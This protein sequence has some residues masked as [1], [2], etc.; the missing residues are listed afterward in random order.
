M[1]F[2]RDN[3]SETNIKLLRI[4]TMIKLNSPTADTFYRQECADYNK[5]LGILQQNSQEWYDS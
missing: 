1:I 3:S 4:H 2:I 5:N